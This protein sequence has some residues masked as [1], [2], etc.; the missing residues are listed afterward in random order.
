VPIFGVSALRRIPTRTLAVAMGV[1]TRWAEIDASML[2]VAM[3]LLK[4]DYKTATAM[5]SAIQNPQSRRAALLAGIDESLGPQDAAL[6]SRVLQRVHD[7]G[8]CRNFLA[9]AIIGYAEQSDPCAAPRLPSD[10]IVAAWPR[11]VARQ[12]AAFQVQT[13]RLMEN[14]LRYRPEGAGATD[15]TTAAPVP[16]TLSLATVGVS[17]SAAPSDIEVWSRRALR[18][19]WRMAGAAAM[20]ITL[21]SVA[22][23]NHPRAAEAR[24]L[25]GQGPLERE[26]RYLEERGTSPGMRPTPRGQP[27]PGCPM[28]YT[29]PKGLRRGFYGDRPL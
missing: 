9:H 22:V 21:L 3:K 19:E 6:A 13:L 10:A 1:I 29:P 15:A 4:S 25:L 26:R 24:G 16:W 27:L 2:H 8:R 5:F 12:G 23:S 11:D 14:V 7:A 18:R 28:P 17:L 20:E